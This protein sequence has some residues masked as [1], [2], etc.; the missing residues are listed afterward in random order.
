MRRVVPPCRRRVGAECPR[1]CREDPGAASPSCRGSEPVA[2][3]PPVSPR[4]Y[5][6]PEPKPPAA[7][8]R[9]PLRPAQL[10]GDR[11]SCAGEKAAQRLLRRQGSLDRLGHPPGSLGG[12]DRHRQAGLLPECRQRARERLGRYVEGLRGRRPAAS[13]ADAAWIRKTMAVVVISEAA[14]RKAGARRMLRPLVGT[15]LSSHGIHISLIAKLQLRVSRIGVDGRG[16]GIFPRQCQFFAPSQRHGLRVT[17]QD[18]QYPAIRMERS[19]PGEQK[20]RPGYECTPHPDGSSG[21]F[22]CWCSPPVPGSRGL[23]SNPVWRPPLSRAAIAASGGAE[24]FRVRRGHGRLLAREDRNQVRGGRQRAE[25]A[26]ALTPEVGSRRTRRQWRPAHA[27]PE[28]PLQHQRQ[29]LGDHP[30]LALRDRAARNPR[31]Q[32]PAAASSAGLPPRA[33]AISAR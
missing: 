1:R 33:G 21:Y 14:R 26:P 20:Y 7:S 19:R 8:W 18:G 32:R 6:S 30:R 2:K 28:A 4:P 10:G 29:A 22:S 31:Q 27:A 17:R 11:D 23:F 9:Q 15:V 5:C 3:G 13:C 12:V 16:G 24:T 25:T